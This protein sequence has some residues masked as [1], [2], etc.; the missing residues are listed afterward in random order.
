MFH[1]RPHQKSTNFVVAG[2]DK[3][4]LTKKEKMNVFL[5]GMQSLGECLLECGLNDCEKRCKLRT[6]SAPFFFMCVSARFCILSGS[7]VVLTKLF[8]SCAGAE[9]KAT[10]RKLTPNSTPSGTP[11]PSPLKVDTSSPP[12]PDIKVSRSSESVRI[13]MKGEDEDEKNE[14]QFPHEAV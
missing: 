4:L 10:L 2:I 9:R 1:S 12:T 3:R 13:S 7:L 5:F 14:G 6:I 8:S 11:D